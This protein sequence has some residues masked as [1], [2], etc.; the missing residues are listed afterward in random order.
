MESPAA[1]ALSPNHPLICRDEPPGMLTQPLWHPPPLVAFPCPHAHILCPGAR[2][3]TWAPCPQDAYYSE[4]LKLSLILPMFLGDRAIRIESSDKTASRRLLSFIPDEESTR[5]F[6]A[7]RFQ[8][9]DNTLMNHL[10]GDELSIL[11]FRSLLHVSR[12]WGVK[13]RSGV[14][15]GQRQHP[16]EERQRRKDSIRK[17]MAGM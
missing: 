9:R 2:Y 12:A 10:G 7:S 4:G 5:G 15:H 8:R 11:G 17:S 3:P 1:S 14:Y 6:M 16:C 13:W